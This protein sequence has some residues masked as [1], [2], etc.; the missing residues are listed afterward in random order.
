MS[1]LIASAVQL[2]KNGESSS[3]V[4]PYTM[5]K[6]KIKFTLNFFKHGN[7]CQPS[8]EACNISTTIRTYVQAQ[9]ICTQI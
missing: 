1:L 5:S 2:C 8:I 3:V 4:L 7:C 9:Y 6:L